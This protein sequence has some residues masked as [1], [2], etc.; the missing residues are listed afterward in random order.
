[1]G[2][3]SPLATQ[4]NFRDSVAKIGRYLCLARLCNLCRVSCSE[5]DAPAAHQLRIV[6]TLPQ[7]SVRD[8]MAKLFLLFRHIC[9][10]I[11]MENNVEGRS[12]YAPAL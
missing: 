10:M 11:F 6:V 12:C 5:I 4:L 3:V 8:E 1:M 9:A 7:Q 2:I